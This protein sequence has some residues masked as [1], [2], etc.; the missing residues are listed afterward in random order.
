MSQFSSGASCNQPRCRVS[1]SSCCQTG[2]CCCQTS[3][4]EDGN[5]MCGYSYWTGLG[6][7]GIQ[8]NRIRLG[9]QLRAQLT[10]KFSFFMRWTNI[11][12]LQIVRTCSFE[13]VRPSVCLDW[14][15]PDFHVFCIDLQ[16]ILSIFAIHPSIY[17][18]DR[19]GPDWATCTLVFL[20][21][22]PGSKFSTLFYPSFSD[23][24]TMPGTAWQQ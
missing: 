24:V 18:L 9:V 19:I 23:R 12:C 1:E 17:P 2:T 10:T 6:E 22:F 4:A 21:P 3:L 7:D 15:G 20:K 13:S 5:Q 8:V 11:L 14:T 16:I